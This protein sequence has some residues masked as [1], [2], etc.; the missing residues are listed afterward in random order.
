MTN[1]ELQYI[2]QLLEALQRKCKTDNLYF[3]TCRGLDIINRELE[4]Q[5]E[6]I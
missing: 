6:I 4:E 2:K 1:K 3:W 5:K